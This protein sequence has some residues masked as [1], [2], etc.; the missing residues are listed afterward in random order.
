MIA[1][2]GRVVLPEGFSTSFLE[3]YH[4]APLLDNGA[5]PGLYVRIKDGNV[6]FQ[7]GVS[8][9]ANADVMLD[10]DFEAIR[11]LSSLYEDDPNFQ[12]AWAEFT[13]SGQLRV[14]G[15]IESLGDWLTGVHDGVVSRTDIRGIKY[16]PQ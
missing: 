15:S 9:A 2:V 11:V 10:A 5:I 14:S 4:G 6:E 7:T 1:G 3:R 8:E 12:T 13:N 16:N